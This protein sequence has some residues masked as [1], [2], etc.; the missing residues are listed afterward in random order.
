M[1]RSRTRRRFYDKYSKFGNSLYSMISSVTAAIVWLI[2]MA[3]IRE[4]FC[5]LVQYNLPK[6]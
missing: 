6:P 3:Y 5:I 1:S 4:A 2:A